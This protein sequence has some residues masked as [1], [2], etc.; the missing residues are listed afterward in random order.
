MIQVEDYNIWQKLASTSS[1]MSF[2]QALKSSEKIRK[3]LEKM[4]PKEERD[5]FRRL[6]VKRL[7]T[8]RTVHTT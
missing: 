3:D 5:S 7:L 2:A 6:D 8:P 4:Y 1:G